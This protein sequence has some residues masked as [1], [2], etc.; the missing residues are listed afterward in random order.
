MVPHDQEAAP[1]RSDT[2][3][4][5]KR[6]NFVNV[7]DKERM[8]S[9]LAGAASIFYGLARRDKQ[10]LGLAALGSYL[11]YRGVSGHCLTYQTLGV[12]TTSERTEGIL[13]DK[14]ITID[15]QPDKLY[16]FWV[17]FE[18]LPQFMDH[19]EAV[20]MIG[21]HRYRWVAKAPAGMSV[22]WDADI[23]EERPGELVA[24]RSLQGSEIANEGSVRFEPA[25]HGL[26]TTVHVSLKYYPPAGKVGAWI[27]KMLGEEPGDQIEADLQ[28]LKEI[29]ESGMGR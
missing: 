3:K 18:N 6:P 22:E 23:I 29:M 14:S 5:W 7:G 4:H 21:D 15:V 8:I 11:V 9:A 25:D 2:A 26:A 10:G 24:W 28:H 20:W 12:N 19:L 13:V 27:A 16:K 17:D 1:V